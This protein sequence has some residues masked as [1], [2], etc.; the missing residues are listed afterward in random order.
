[1]VWKGLAIQIEPFELF[2]A[3]CTGRHFGTDS[4]WAEYSADSMFNIECCEK[5][6][7]CLVLEQKKWFKFLI[8]AIHCKFEKLRKFFSLFKESHFSRTSQVHVESGGRD[9]E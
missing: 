3:F 5:E 6:H 9:C 1:M 2:L 8:K 7:V 4:G